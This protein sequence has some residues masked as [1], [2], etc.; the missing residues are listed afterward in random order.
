MEEATLPPRLR[1][2][3]YELPGKIFYALKEKN[4]HR[5]NR[6]ILLSWRLLFNCLIRKE[7]P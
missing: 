5:I 2:E 7:P 4:L 3:I 1:G 6:S